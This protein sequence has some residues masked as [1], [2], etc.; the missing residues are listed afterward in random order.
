MSSLLI[1]I[2]FPESYDSDMIDLD[3][4]VDLSGSLLGGDTCSFPFIEFIN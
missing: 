3:L 1:S 2:A 4:R